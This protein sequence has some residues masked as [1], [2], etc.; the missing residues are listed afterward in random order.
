[1][2]RTIGLT[3][4][5]LRD[6]QQSQLATRMPF[7]D[8]EPILSTMDEVGYYSVECW[9]GAT[10][11]ACLRYLYEDPWERLRRIRKAMPKTKLQMLLRGQNLLGYRPYP[12]D[13]VE[14]FIRLS[15]K[16][17]IDI[18]RI[19]DGLNDVRNLEVAIRATKKYG[20]LASGAICY[21]NSPVHTLDSF[22]S[23]ACRLRDLGCDSICIKDMGGIMGPQEAYDLV[24]AIKSTVHLPLV[25]HTHSTT[26][27][28]PFTMLKAVEAGADVLDTACSA[29]AGGTSQYP[30]ESTA[31]AL[32]QLGYDVH[33]DDAKARKVNEHFTPLQKKY[34]ADGLLDPYCLSTRPEGLV[35]QIPG[36]MLSNLIAQLKSQNA[37]DRLDEVLAEVPNVRRDLGYPPLVT[38]MSQMVGVQASVNVLMGKRYQML[39]SEVKSYIRG[40]YGK[41]PGPLD[42]DLVRRVCGENGH[43]MTGR[44][45]DTLPPRVESAREELGRHAKCDEDVLSYIAF[46][47]VATQFFEWRD[48]GKP[49]PTH[50]KP[51]EEDEST[52]AKLILDENMLAAIETVMEAVQNLH[53][54]MGGA[55]RKAAASKAAKTA[56]PAKPAEDDD[57]DHIVSPT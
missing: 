2:N 22:I 40:E 20:A 53:R 25:I 11:D 38:P 37:A 15:V 51:K 12:D 49:L 26:G 23:L 42:P 45:A 14:N 46:P 34:I 41:A 56:A 8:F 35:Y 4:T 30:T 19:F 32:R 48:D 50:A 43:P 18:I 13:V 55:G 10:F 1:M 44:F 6:G 33:I 57:H 5:V 39:T 9:G 3:E 29:L 16:N 17:G 28:A 7:E 31:Y 36:G 47:Q 24:T 27:Q 21:T 52:Q 54:H